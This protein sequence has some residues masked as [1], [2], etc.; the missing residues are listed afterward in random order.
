MFIPP[1][2]TNRIRLGRLLDWIADEAGPADS[3]RCWTRP[4]GAAGAS[5]SVTLTAQLG[6]INQLT[7]L[8]TDPWTHPLVAQ[9]VVELARQLTDAQAEAALL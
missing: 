2:G 8:T 4:V 3:H 1:T 5:I 6:F 9:A 7:T